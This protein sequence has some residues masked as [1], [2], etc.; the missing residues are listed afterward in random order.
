[1]EQEPALASR[2]DNP[3]EREVGA[4]TGRLGLACTCLRLSF[5]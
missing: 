4:V 1:M 2:S 5:R 3:A